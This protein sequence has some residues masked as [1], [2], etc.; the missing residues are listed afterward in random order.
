MDIAGFMVAFAV[1]RMVWILHYRRQSR[2][3][4]IPWLVL[5]V[6]GTLGAVASE[7][8][9][10]VISVGMGATFLAYYSVKWHHSLLRPESGKAY[11]RHYQ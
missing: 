5:M 4:V 11:D 3:Y 1:V 9:S 6:F 8:R 7:Y 10:A 2:L